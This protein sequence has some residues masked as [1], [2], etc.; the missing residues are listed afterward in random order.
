[1]LTH[2]RTVLLLGDIVAL[3]AAFCAMA[4]IRFDVAAQGVRI[5]EQIKLFAI[6]YIVWLIVFFVFDLY[7]LRRANPN[8]RNIGL[9]FAAMSINVLLGVLL[10]YLVSDAGI[11]P[12]TNLAILT[13]SALIFLIAWRRI[14]Y[15]L[16]T[17]RFVRRILIIG[18][19]PFTEHLAGELKT[20]PHFGVIVAHWKTVSDY[21]HGTTADLVIADRV[22]PETLLRLSQHLD[23]ETL[24]LVEAYEMIFAKIPVE[25]MTD[26]RAIQLM[27]NRITPAKHFIYRFLE[28]IIASLILI[29]T[30]PL[31]LIAI[32]A[33][34]IEDGK[35]I[36]IKQT[37]V[38][39]HGKIFNIYKIRSMKALAPDGSAEQTGAQWADKVDPRIT[40]VGRILRKTH[41]DEAP[42]MWNIIK[43]DLALVGPRPE[44]PEF[45]DTLEKEIPYYYLRHSIRPGFTGWAQIKYRYA[46]TVLDSREK[47]EYDLYYIA[48]KHPLLDMGIF[49]KTVQIIFTH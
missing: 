23:T 14:F 42:Q 30:S 34:L 40:P 45:V 10:F 12:K 18:K 36:F 28:V 38:G 3:V 27:T 35:P 19:N 15:I 24:S 43:G 4:L 8:P 47:F 41:I 7:N 1:M 16:F 22:D 2:R 17:K 37:R 9:L 33:R 39:K 25:L 5:W 21:V 31:L 13:G 6:L 20:N 44:R 11:S 32:S 49:L 48:N 29:A 46:G 26:E